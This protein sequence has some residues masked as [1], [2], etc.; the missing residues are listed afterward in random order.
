MIYNFLFSPL[1]AG[2]KKIMMEIFLV[3]EGYSYEDSQDVLGAYSTREKA[4]KKIETEMEKY[5]G[6]YSINI[7]EF[8]KSFD[9]HWEEKLGGKIYNILKMEVDK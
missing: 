7:P 6:R 5:K 2:E 3:E 8:V 9:N 4:E 1:E